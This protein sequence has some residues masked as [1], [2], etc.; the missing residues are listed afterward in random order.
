MKQSQQGFTLIEL[1]VVISI[2]GLLASVILVALNG[3][4]IKARDAKR[5]ADLHQIATALELYAEDHNGSY[6]PSGCGYDCNGYDYSFDST[7]WNALQTALAPY[8]SKLPADPINS[9]CAPWTTGCYSYTYGNVGNTTY[10][11]Q[12]DLT[13]QL[14]DQNSSYRCTA[15]HYVF[16]FNGSIQWCVNSYSGQ[17]YEASPQ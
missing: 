3:A 2:I 15:R 14:E 17:I 11:P 10:T 6:P 16:Y 7:T 8:M 9:A 12:Y 4:R 1:L 5:I 13:T